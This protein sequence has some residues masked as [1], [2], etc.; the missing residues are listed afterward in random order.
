LHTLPRS[1]EQRAESR[2]QKGAKVKGDG[3][4]REKKGDDELKPAY[5]KRFFANKECF[6]CEKL[7]GHPANSCPNQSA[8]DEKPAGKGKS[9]KKEEANDDNALVSLRNLK[10]DSRRCREPSCR[11]MIRLT[12]AM[13]GIY[14]QGGFTLPVHICTS[15][16]GG[17]FPQNC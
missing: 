6:N 13:S 4:D 3:K 5:N 15:C 17:R 10:K 8:D 9:K 2:E 14:L 11:S 12:K 1:R 16:Y 7:V